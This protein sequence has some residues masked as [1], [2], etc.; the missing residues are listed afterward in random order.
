MMK[1]K[2]DIIVVGSGP[3]GSMAALEAAKAGCSVCIL[4]K[5]KEVG[6]PVRCGEAVGYS[7]LTQFMQPKKEWIASTINSIQ[8]VS[9]NNTSVDINFNLETGFILNR[10][11]FD[12]DLSKMAVDAGAEIYTGAYVEDLVISDGFIST[13]TNNSTFS[14]TIVK[15]VLPGE[16]TDPAYRSS[17]LRIHL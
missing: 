5:T 13:E 16:I 12:S 8:L 10:N 2:Y 1:K 17:I 11:I 14:G 15:I 7:G 3:T 4:E 6:S 9:P